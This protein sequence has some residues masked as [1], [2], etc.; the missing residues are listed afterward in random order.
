MISTRKKSGARSKPI[1]LK[2]KMARL[3]VD[4]PVMV[5]SPADC[6]REETRLV[7]PRQKVGR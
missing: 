3:I 7:I 6:H 4:R 1:C 2:M 5:Y